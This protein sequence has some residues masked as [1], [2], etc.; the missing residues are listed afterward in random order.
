MTAS[1]EV[2][3]EAPASAVYATLMDAW[4]YSTWVK[5]TKRIRD[6]DADWPAPGSRFHHSVGV[7]P[8]ATR[9]ETRM[10][11]AE[12]DSLVVLDVHIWPAGE[13]TVRIE[14]H[15]EADGRT[16]VT[17]QERFDEGPAA[18][19]EGALQQALIKL[20]NEWGLDKL[21][22]MVEQRHNMRL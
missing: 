11:T 4:S 10:V 14:L 3:I 19:T 13:A 2:E 9:D 5:G 12:K 7:G 17:L 1:T 20:R 15:E 8:I 16:R 22:T 6:V 21:K 18:M